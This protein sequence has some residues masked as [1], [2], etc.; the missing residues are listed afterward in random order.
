MSFF[1]F[2]IDCQESPL[3]GTLLPLAWRVMY[4]ATTIAEFGGGLSSTSFTLLGAR[5][6]TRGGGGGDG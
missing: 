2:P 3:A 4:P 1:N 6:P 5:A